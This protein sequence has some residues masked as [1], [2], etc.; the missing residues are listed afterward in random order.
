MV[1]HCDPIVLYVVVAGISL[2]EVGVFLAVFVTLLALFAVFPCGLSVE[3]VA[4]FGMVVLLLEE[5]AMPPA[6]VVM[7]SAMFP[8]H[9][10]SVA[11]RFVVGW[12]ASLV[13]PMVH[14]SERNLIPQVPLGISRVL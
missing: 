10:V 9:L 7:L 12:L 11:A 4:C 6:I 13:D 3:S 2:L 8:V 14:V 5:V 1:G